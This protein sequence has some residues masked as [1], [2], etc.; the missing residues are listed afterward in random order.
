MIIIIDY[1]KEDNK[2]EIL[3]T[4]DEQ[5]EDINVNI[6]KSKELQKQVININ[7]EIVTI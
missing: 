6:D 5:L 1:S 7:D 2:E 4:S 3:E